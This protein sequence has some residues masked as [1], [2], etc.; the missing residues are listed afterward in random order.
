MSQHDMDIAN[1]AAADLRADLNNALQ[2]L[3]STSSGRAVPQRHTPISFG[4]KLTQA[5]CLSKVERIR[6]A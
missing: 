3:A 5:S 4:T 2:A 1:Q 6:V